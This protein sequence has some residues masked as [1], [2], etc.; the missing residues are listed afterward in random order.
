MIIIKTAKTLFLVLQLFAH[1]T[2]LWVHLPFSFLHR[3]CLQ[4]RMVQLLH[5]PI[6]G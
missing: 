3:K 1:L 5:Q 6:P 4:K 2:L